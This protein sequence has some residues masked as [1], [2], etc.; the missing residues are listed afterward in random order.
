[1]N[2][3]FLHVDGNEEQALEFLHIDHAESY[4]VSK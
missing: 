3:F 2:Q 1:M 4:N